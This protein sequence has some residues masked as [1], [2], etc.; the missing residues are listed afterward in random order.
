MPKVA[1][2]QSNI[3]TPA[4]VEVYYIGDDSEDVAFATVAEAVTFVV[5]I[6]NTNPEILARAPVIRPALFSIN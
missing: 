2:A 4:I 6:T 3:D 1:E 5:V